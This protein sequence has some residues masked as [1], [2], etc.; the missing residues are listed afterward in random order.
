M[1][2]KYKTGAISF[3]LKNGTQ[4]VKFLYELGQ[5]KSVSLVDQI[6]EGSTNFKS[7][8]LSDLSFY[9]IRIKN[10][11]VISDS[12]VVFIESIDHSVGYLIY[13][14][15]T[16]LGG[17][18]IR[19]LEGIVAEHLLSPNGVWAFKGSTKLFFHYYSTTIGNNIKSLDYSLRVSFSECYVSLK[20]KSSNY[21][22]SEIS[23]M[24]GNGKGLRKTRVIRAQTKP[25]NSKVNIKMKKALA[26]KDVNFFT[27]FEIDLFKY[28]NFTGQGIDI[29]YPLTKK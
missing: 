12:G 14:F 3:K 17:L 28:F 9:K 6:S 4:K 20:T 2:V 29:N 18:I 21:K 19:R 1:G 15:P 22:I 13:I 10:F 5:L 11:R 23:I 25:N 24:M 26:I 27:E 8:V 7:P 16:S